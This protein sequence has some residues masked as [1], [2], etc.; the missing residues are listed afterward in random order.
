MRKPK[1]LFLMQ[2]PPPV[3]GASVVNK[4]IM[5]SPRLNSTFNTLFFNISPAKDLTDIGNFSLKKI[6]LFLSI[7]FNS[8]RLYLKFKP[9][10]VYLTLSP[11]GLGLYKDGIIALIIKAFGGKLVFHLHGKGIKKT[12][13]SNKFKLYVYRLIFKKASIIHLAQS[14]FYDVEPVR[15]R[16]SSLVAIPNGISPPQVT[17]DNTKKQSTFTFIY[18]SNLV[19]TKGADILIK[20]ASI[21]NK[22]HSGL[23]KVKIIGKPS[24]LQYKEELDSLITPE[25][26][27]SIS[28]LGPLYDK[29]KTDELSSSHVFVLP[30]KNDCFPL[31]ILEAMAAGLVV[32][33]TNEGAISDIVDHGVTGELLQEATPESLAEVMIR[34][35]D[36][37]TYYSSCAL[38]GHKKFMLQYTKSTFEHNLITELSKLTNRH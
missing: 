30:T 12:A 21:V 4:S 20:A 8:T 3:H 10:L 13:E 9:D 5:D 15:D 28:F 33:S 29:K 31:S 17:V 23:F 7:A 26:H 37:S 6:F 34:F 18:L 16:S 22:T 27:N 35:I 19:R 38:A 14:L 11:H 32:I 1:I 24:N 2:L 25:L 36:D